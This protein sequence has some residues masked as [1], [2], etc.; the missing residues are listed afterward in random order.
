[1]ALE[2][3]EI[4]TRIRYRDGDPFGDV[5][6][7]ERLDGTAHFAVD[8]MDPSNRGIVDLA[9]AERGSD[10]SVR[11]TADF[12]LLQPTEPAR[13]NR[14]LVFE[15]LNRGRKL[16]PRHLNHAAPE[17]VPSAE[18]DPGGGFLMR[19]G[20]T[21]AWCGWQWD[22][23]RSPALMGL[24]APMALEGGQPIRGQVA[25]EFQPNERLAA[26][27]LANRV[28]QPYPAADVND[29][30][31]VLTVRNWPYGSRTTIPRDRWRFAREDGGQPV[32]DDAHVWL[33]DGFEPGKMYEVV[34][35]TRICPVVG[36]GL[37]AVRDA[38]AFLRHASAAEGNP[39][40]GRLDTLYSFGMSQSGR[41]QRHFLY[42]G[43]NLDERG[44]PVFDG[45]LV[46]VAGARRG[47]FNH[48][49]G[50]PSVQ[51]TPSFGHLFPFSDDEQADPLTGET[52]GLLR[53]QRQLGGVPKIVYT[54]TS[55]EY[56]RGD[57]A[58][59]HV[60][61]D[62]SRDL[63]LPDGVRN[64]HFASTQH[65]LGVV[66][67]VDRDPNE[68]SRGAQGF[69]AV[70]YAPL[71]R[72]AL[73]N[74]DRWVSDG[75]EPPASAHPRLSDGTA[76]DAEAALEPFAGFP[77]IIR[78][79]PDLLPH[80]W[81]LD[82]GSGSQQGVGQYP[83]QHRGSR[84]RLVPAVDAD[85]N[86]L[87]GLRMPDVSVPVA[88]YPGWNPRHPLTGGE[89]QIISMNGST[90]PFPATPEERQRTSDPRPSVAERY[91]DRDDYLSRVRAAAEAL[92]AERYMLEEDVPMAI[93]LAAERYDALVRQSE[94]SHR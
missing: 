68:G 20:W 2:R 19:R 6:P 37:L 82:L 31:A 30:N 76:V 70:D 53:S 78:P 26:K 39:C 64:Y 66:P 15:V 42:L 23:V 36:A 86:E 61:I 21:I 50:Q 46:H 90:L 71:L 74:L 3:L 83:A 38:P 59:G 17:P 55:A 75:V 44:R 67:L 93:A 18:I 32:A 52:D 7:Y 4:H 49:F 45:M 92:V 89:G 57:C 10:G 48:R 16:L 84:P 60:S 5:G 40:A 43:L 1:M 88:T 14:R 8:P 25:C 91:R 24:E 80:L 34:Y 47:E 28:H 72:A 73:V 56:W 69:N 12:C 9:R 94:P 77:G 27:L 29:P 41:F 63:D 51:N 87:G 13:G 62:G 58:L 11:F 79:N 35:E 65:G 85:G 81:H 54:N 33:E 22:V